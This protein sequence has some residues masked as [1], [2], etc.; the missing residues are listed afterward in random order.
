MN[1]VV[2]VLLILAAIFIAF[3]ALSPWPITTPATSPYRRL[4]WGWLGVLM[5]V[6]A[7]LWIVLHG[8]SPVAITR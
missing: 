1:I 5:L 6:L 2:L 7:L 4:H 3:A 8:G